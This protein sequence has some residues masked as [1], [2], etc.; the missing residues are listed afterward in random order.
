[1][2]ELRSD[3]PWALLLL[4]EDVARLAVDVGEHAV[5]AALYGG[6]DALRDEVDSERPPNV[7]EQVDVATAAI[8]A[9]IGEEERVTAWWAGAARSRADTVAE[10]HSLCARLAGGHAA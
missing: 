10:V 7:Q 3:D 2:L 8:D 4:V 1:M 9:A 5:A 6:A